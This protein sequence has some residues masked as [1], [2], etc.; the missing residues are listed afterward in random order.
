MDRKRLHEKTDQCAEE[1]TA[2]LVRTIARLEQQVA[3]YD[4]AGLALQE[5]EAKYRQLIANLPNVV[6]K[7]YED[8]SVDF[9]DDKIEQLTGYKREDFE[10]RRLKWFDLVVEEDVQGVRDA[11]KEALRGERSYVRE[12]RIKARSGEILW[13]QEGSHIV[14]DNEG[15]VESVRG[16]FLE[17]TERKR[18]EEQIRKLN[19]ELERRVAERTA[20]LSHSLE[21]LREAQWQLV[22]SEKMAALGGLVAGVAHEINTPVG[23]GVT[24]VSLLDEKTREC[25]ALLSSGKLKRSDL[26][27]Y[28]SLAAG[29]TEMIMTNLRR[30]ADL[31][32]S[33]KQVAVDQSTEERR[34]FNLK[35]YIE[36]VLLSL[37]PKLKK[38][39]HRIT[40]NC[41][42]DLA[43]DSYAG[44]FS[45]IITNL[46]M[47][48]LVHGFEEMEEGRIV[49]DIAEEDGTVIFKYS[50]NGRGMAEKIVSR[51]FEPF[52]TTRRGTGGSG[53]GLHIVYNLVTQTLGGQISCTSAP[54]KGA[55]FLIRIPLK[56][57]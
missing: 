51:I 6:F 25:S 7:G 41:P 14:C 23:I 37:R 38:T 42:G 13:V 52:F 32:Q 40:V 3:R 46:V 9:F 49:F 26:E 4:H 24:A 27:A 10:S 29:S 35:E 12:Y 28:L 15:R 56:T 53:L 5:S 54:G 43:L 2:D 8:G 31:I 22:Q 34:R 17:I 50:D 30:A 33:F 20:E 36:H 44:A 57:E 18:S 48:S 55:L 47:N 16:A 1:R 11:F 39:R 21:L 19:D 45:Q